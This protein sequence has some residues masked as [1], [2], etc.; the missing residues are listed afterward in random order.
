MGR[1]QVEMFATLDGLISNDHPYRKFETII[2]LDTLSQPLCALYSDLGRPELGAE[3]AFR[4]LVLQFLEDVSDREMERFMRE[5][6]AAK[7]FC[8]FGLSD[9]TPDHSFFGDFRK[10]LGTKRLMEI[11]N[12]L[13]MSLKEAGLI[14]EVFTFVDASRL[15]SKLSIWEDRD[16]AIAK[17]LEK[18]NNETAPKVAADK[19]ARF[20]AKGK[21]KFWYGYKEHTSVD[22]QSGLINKVAATPANIDDAKGLRHV[23]PDQGAVYADKGYC[24]APAQQ[25]LKRKGCHSA[26]IKKNNMVGK[27]RDK[28]RWLSKMR[29]PYERVYSKRPNQ[30]S[31][32]GQAKVQFQVACQSICHNLKRLITL[33]VEKVPIVTV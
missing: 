30:V 19:Q 16:R 2:D 4:M 14:R 10:R 32:R 9:K 18:F 17:G 11:F 1:N 8:G 31:Y 24:T 23:C 15:V 12:R 28:D 26:A 21:N 27:D 20:G 25:A 3:R 33:G 7:W 5:N 13:R 22:M 29:A 6:L